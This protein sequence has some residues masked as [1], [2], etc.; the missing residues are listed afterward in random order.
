[1]SGTCDQGR[2]VGSIPYSSS[3]DTPANVKSIV[4]A[5]AGAGRISV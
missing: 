1:P 4:T 2:S 5:G 3:L